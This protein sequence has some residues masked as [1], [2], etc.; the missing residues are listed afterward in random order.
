MRVRCKC[1]GGKTTTVP[2]V[3]G[4]PACGEVL[5]K[6][7]EVEETLPSAAET[8]PSAAETLPDDF[9]HCI[10]T[11]CPKKEEC[12]RWTTEG[13]KRWVWYPDTVEATPDCEIFIP[14]EVSDDT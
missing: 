2:M 14:K 7:E 5:C 1:I 3:N 9:I 10:T 8:S 12:L 13:T 4:L 11:L 6:A